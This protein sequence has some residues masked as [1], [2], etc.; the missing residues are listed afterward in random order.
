LAGRDPVAVDTVCAALIGLDP[1]QVRHLQLAHEAGLGVAELSRILIA[2]ERIES[3]KRPFMSWADS[4][5]A[6][7]GAVRLV[8]KDACTGCMGEM[9]SILIYLKQAGFGDRLGD[10][11]LV[12]GRVEA[13]PDDLPP[14]VVI[15]GKCAEAHR[16]RGVWVPGC[17]P[18]GMDMTRGACQALGLDWAVVQAA[19]DKLHDF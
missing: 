10:L 18:H 19:V 15:M 13:L 12:F 14:G 16:G 1:A 2:G 4:V 8:E 3:L 17:P 6:R 7:F 11:A 5:K 9:T